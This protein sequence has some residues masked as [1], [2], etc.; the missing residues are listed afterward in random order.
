MKMKHIFP[1][2]AIFLIA[3]AIWYD[4]KSLAFFSCI[5]LFPAVLLFQLREKTPVILK[6]ITRWKRF[7]LVFYFAITSAFLSSF[8]PSFLKRY[9]FQGVGPESFYLLLDSANDASFLMVFLIFPTVM[10][11]VIV[12][13]IIA[14]LE[15]FS[16][17]K[18]GYRDP[19]TGEEHISLRYCVFGQVLGKVE[20][21]VARGAEVG[22]DF[23]SKLIAKHSLSLASDLDKAF[24]EFKSKWVESDEKSGWL[25]SV[26]FSGDG[27]TRKE[28]SITSSFAKRLCVGRKGEVESGDS[29][30]PHCSFLEGYVSGIM[31]SVFPEKNPKVSVRMSHCK[32]CEEDP[33]AQEL[34]LFDI[35]FHG[36]ERGAD[37]SSP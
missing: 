18:G 35:D 15:H 3:V 8:V 33:E 24:R 22:G 9:D 7:V 14:S 25:E 28:L 19:T 30:T 6:W 17:H 13:Q 21:P 10:L 23:A 29:C 20:N 37:K 36:S 1:V 11:A 26:S 27:D 12:N 16:H 32:K 31:E 4:K 2:I 34:C 5:Y